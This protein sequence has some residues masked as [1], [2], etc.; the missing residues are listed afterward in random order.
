[1]YKMIRPILFLMSADTAHSVV[2]YFMEHILKFIPI[3]PFVRGICKSRSKLLR[4]KCDGLLISNPVGLAAGF[5]KNA[6]M[7]SFLEMLGFGVLEI[8]SITFFPSNGNPKPRMIRLIDESSLINRCGL[9]NEGTSSVA[10]RFKELHKKIKIPVGIN[11]SKTHDPLILGKE[12]ISDYKCSF[13]LVSDIADYITINISCPNT[14][15]GKTFENV[16]SLDKLLR[17]LNLHSCKVPVY[18][19][20]SA[21][22]SDEDINGVI[23][24]A[25]EFNISGYIISN[26]S[27]NRNLLTDKSKEIADKFGKGGLSGEAIKDNTFELIKKIYKIAPK[28]TTIIA[29][30]GIST[31]DDVYNAISYGANFVQIYTAFIFKGPL[32]VRNINCELSKRLKKENITLSELRGSF[33][34]C[35]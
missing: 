7:M 19:K 35:K 21:D 5:D 3:K 23:N 10:Y 16:E 34:S 33:H 11:I 25:T 28:G 17:E 29:S 4:Q 27:S 6:T 12:G 22:L 8:G 18:L 14:E 1:M 24:K 9:N 20:I 13:D 30:G 2:A 32:V 31:A 26:T 15:E